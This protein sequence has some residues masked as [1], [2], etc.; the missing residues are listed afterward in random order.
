MKIYHLSHIDLDGYGCQFVAREFFK[1]ITFYNANYGKEVMAR[2]NAILGNISSYKMRGNSNTATLF[3]K[4]IKIEQKNP[5]Q[6]NQ[7]K[8]KFIIL[9]TDLNLTLNESKFLSEQVKEL[10]VAGLDIEIILLDHH[11]TG[12]ESAKM[13]SWY[14]LDV[15]RCATKITYEYLLERFGLQESTQVW[16][17]PM[18]E[19]INSVDIWVES[20]FGFEFG[21]V[22]MSMIAT[23]NELNRFM[24]D[25][26]SRDYKLNL[27]QYARDFLKDSHVNKVGGLIEGKAFDEVEFDNAIFFLK[28]VALGGDKETETM[29]NIVS[30]AQVK[31]L[32]MKKDECKIYYK[33]KTG[34]LSYCMGGISVVANR[35][36]HENKDEFDF[37]IDVS[38]R[39]NVSLRSNGGCDVSA[40]SQ[41]CFHGGGHKNASGGRI[42]NFRESFLYEDIKAQVQGI[43]EMR[44]EWDL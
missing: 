7:T 41:E 17:K 11:A 12:E 9:I 18:V 44:D 15:N 1:D 34:F 36:L 19:M 6:Q 43:L 21:K 13:Y 5:I 14:H 42:E 25:T 16:L 10:K 31:L 38:N 37:Y 28:K 3:G 4:T 30:R 39:G 22:A 23:S 40:L 8:E 2:L 24:F 32:E 26:E 35:F 20:G 29:D 33:D 27:L